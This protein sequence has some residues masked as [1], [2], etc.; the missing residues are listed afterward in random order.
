MSLTRKQAA[1][2][3]FLKIEIARNGFAP[4]YDEM[5]RSLGITV[6]TVAE[7]LQNL[8]RKGYIRRER[9]KARS[10]E[11]V[12]RDAIRCAVDETIDLIR[13][14][15]DGEGTVPWGDGR[16]DFLALADEIRELAS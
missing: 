10:I 1:I 8:E 14:K 6:A 4:S 5:V 13:R 11:I 12:D 3:D 7:H 16:A 2:L 15:C 9:M